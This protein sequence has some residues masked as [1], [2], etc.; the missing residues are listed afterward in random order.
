M[1][2]FVPFQA[3]VHA[4][5]G[6]VTEAQQEV[7]K[8]HIANLLAYLDREQRPLTLRIRVPSIRPEAAPGEED[9]YQ[10][11]LLA[12]VP[13]SAMRIKQVEISFDLQLGDLTKAT[14]QKS[15]VASSKAAQALAAKLTQ[16]VNVNPVVSGAVKREGTSAHVVLTVE[17]AEPSE[18][19]SRLVT[20]MTKIQGIAGAVAKDSK[21]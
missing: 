4:L 15:D 21:G 19:V 14:R 8:A 17:G 18:S 11:P 6:A 3:L 2:E 12:L 16:A 20:E 10:A 9:Y 5:A 13:H 7:E 1:A